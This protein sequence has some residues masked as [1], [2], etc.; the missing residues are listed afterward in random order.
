MLEQYSVTQRWP[1][2]DQ[3][4]IQL[5]SVDTPN[6]LKVSA[7]LEETGLRY[8]KHTLD[9]AA[10]DQLSAEFQSLNPNQKIQA[11][12]DPHGIDGRPLALWESGAILQYLAEKT[13]RFLPHDH[14]ARYE[15]LQWL[16]WASSAVGPMFPQFGFYHAGAG[17]NWQDKQPLGKYAR[18]T[19]R[20][21]GVLNQRLKDHKY[22]MGNE[23]TIADI[24]T[25]P[26]VQAL[27]R[28]YKAAD[29]LELER[30]SH[31]TQWL[32]LCLERTASV[33][34]LQP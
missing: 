22:I 21:L 8:E 5:Y 13:G 20:L 16:M 33:A 28:H 6:G 25:W 17:A 11:I 7:M 18:E 19:R 26:W 30:Y 3:D 34:V 1:S 14:H 4:A 31:A 32:N 10:G 27:S 12:I 24:A 2:T 23:Y 29:E 9:L 15:T